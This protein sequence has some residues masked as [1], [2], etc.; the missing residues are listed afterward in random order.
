MAAILLHGRGG[1]AQDILALEG[2][3][4]LSA[5]SY[6]APQAEGDSWYPQSF[7][8]PLEQNQPQLD[9]ALAVIDSLVDELGQRGIAPQ[10][11][12]WAASRRG[13]AWRWNTQRGAAKSSAACWP[14]QGRL[15]TLEHSGD[16]AGTP[17]LMGVAPDDAHIP[18]E[19]FEASA[20]ALKSMGAQVNAQVY[21][22]LG[23]T[24]NKAELDAARALMQRAVELS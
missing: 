16:L 9:Q 19:R 8:A 13:P 14:S 22:G 21:P 11:S 15:I 7:L 24:I 23:H 12:C 6:L 4:N 17:V 10:Q 20:A 3:L 1:T 2:E 5:F 18:L